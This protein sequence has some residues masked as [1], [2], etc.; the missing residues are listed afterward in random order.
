ML[1]KS[2]ENLLKWI[3]KKK[4]TEINIMRGTKLSLQ[5]TWNKIHHVNIENIRLYI[6]QKLNYLCRGEI[7]REPAKTITTALQAN[8]KY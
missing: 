3:K 8:V 1:D 5:I 6:M 7:H 4:D 2:E